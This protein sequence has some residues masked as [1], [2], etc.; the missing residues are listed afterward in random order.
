LTTVIFFPMNEKP[1]GSPYLPT[2]TTTKDINPLVKKYKEE[3]PRKVT[4]R[5]L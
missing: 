1:K 3:I 5:K 2:Q 4:I